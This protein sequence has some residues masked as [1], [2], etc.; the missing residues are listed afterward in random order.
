[1]P[2]IVRWIYKGRECK[3]IAKKPGKSLIEIHGEADRQWVDDKELARIDAKNW[4][5][6]K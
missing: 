6:K 2:K 4:T 1:M 3:T 5:V